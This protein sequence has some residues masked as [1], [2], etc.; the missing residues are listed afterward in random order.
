MMLAW[1]WVP[2]VLFV[3][4]KEPDHM[5]TMGQWKEELMKLQIQ[6][7]LFWKRDTQALLDGSSD[8]HPSSNRLAGFVFL[9][10]SV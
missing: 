8:A 1:Y 9:F 6:Y 7:N 2:K 10:V 3:D 5:K 4:T